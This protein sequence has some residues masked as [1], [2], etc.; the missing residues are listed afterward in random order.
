MAPKRIRSIGLPA[1]GGGTR[2]SR[3]VF[4]DEG[5]FVL[6]PRSSD[7]AGRLHPAEPFPT[8][9]PGDS[10]PGGG[11]QRSVPVE[12]RRGAARRALGRTGRT[13]AL[14][15]CAHCGRF[16]GFRLWP[17]TDRALLVHTHGLCD[18]CLLQI[19]EEDLSPR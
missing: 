6:G 18:P 15:W 12:G 9:V 4:G 17:R 2:A 14:R 7:D 11:G 3:P 10:G 8:P 1:H 19:P 5:S 13:L 16:L